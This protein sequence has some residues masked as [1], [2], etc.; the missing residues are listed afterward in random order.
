MRVF[1]KI[2]LLDLKKWSHWTDFN[3]VAGFGLDVK[4]HARFQRRP[5][6]DLDIISVTARLV[7]EFRPDFENEAFLMIACVDPSK[8]KTRK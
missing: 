7:Y 8:E 1:D 3:G 4:I 2:L 6:D 5:G